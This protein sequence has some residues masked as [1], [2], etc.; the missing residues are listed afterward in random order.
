MSEEEHNITKS[1]KSESRSWSTGYLRRGG[2]VGLD[3]TTCDPVGLSSLGAAFVQVAD[4][5]AQR[6]RQCE[7]IRKDQIRQTGVQ[8]RSLAV[9]KPGLCASIPE[10]GLQSN[11]G[12]SRRIAWFVLGGTAKVVG[13]V[14]PTEMG[15]S[16]RWV[17]PTLHRRF[18]GCTQVRRVRIKVSFLETP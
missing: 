17:S 1:M 6:P 12:R 15:P 16:H 10:L 11:G 9:G 4:G 5:L 18:R 8:A 14:K 3:G 7:R 13:W 2:F